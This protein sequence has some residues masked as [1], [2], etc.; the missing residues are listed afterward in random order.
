MVVQ[1]S[2]AILGGANS[3]KSQARAQNTIRRTPSGMDLGF[4]KPGTPGAVESGDTQGVGA[5]EHLEHR[6][7]EELAQI[8]AIRVGDSTVTLP[9]HFSTWYR[10]WV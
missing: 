2:K 1:S 9:A 5:W 6:G 7:L 4:C 8:L 3:S 10:L